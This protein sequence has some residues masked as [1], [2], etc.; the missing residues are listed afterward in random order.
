LVKRA[1]ASL[2]EAARHFEE[3]VALDPEYALA[4]IGLAETYALQIMY[5]DLSIDEQR[6]RAKP[7][8]D[9]ALAIDDRLGEAYVV[10]AVLGADSAERE[11]LYKKG[12]K[13]APGYAT[14]RQWYSEFLT[15]QGRGT[16]A[17]EQLREASR[18]DPLSSI[19]RTKL[20]DTLQSLGRFDEARDTYEAILRIDPDFAYAHFA[21][22]DMAWFVHGRLDE[23][24][25]RIRQAAALDP[26]NPLYPSY[27]AALWSDL[28]S[29]ADA[30]RWVETA[31]AIPGS[32]FFVDSATIYIKWNRGD[33]AAA[34]PDAEAMLADVPS[35]AFALWTLGLDDLQNGKGGDAVARYRAAYPALRDE[36]N[37]PIDN[38]N[39]YAAIDLAYVL[40]ATGE[41]AR[42]RQLLD[43]VVS[44]LHTMPRMSSR[45]Y[46]MN[47][48]RIHAMQGN[49]Q[50]A[51]A[52]LREAVDAGWRVYWR[53]YLQHD[54]ALAA[55]RGEPEY[56]SII[57]KLQ[58]DM[59]AQLERVRSLEADGRLEGVSD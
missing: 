25:L 28:G 18:L 21:V 2:L 14:G 5:S 9:K 58:A 35:D 33:L 57:E 42:A 56:A 4:Y 23:A 22:G 31:R 36:A 32:G 15:Y 26:G 37:A 47:D 8:I 48:V 30:E 20:G 45:G 39:Y 7:L 53:V 19:I 12:L 50:Q 17:L 43:R 10:M 16:E 44:H 34:L 46:W 27:V 41:S 13:L 55:L 52:A 40:L 29:D 38:S 6:T 51:L 54:P 3:A 11:A 59:A 49:K 1:S 24:V